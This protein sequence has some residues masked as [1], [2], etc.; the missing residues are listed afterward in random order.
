MS[1]HT[2]LR[3]PEIYTEPMKFIPERWMG[4]AEEVRALD[5]FFVP[6]AKG[7]SSCMGQRYVASSS[8]TSSRPVALIYNSMTYSWLYAVIG[9]VVRKFQL[10]LH[11]T[12]EK[13]VEISRDCFNGQTV[14]GLNLINVKVTKE[15]N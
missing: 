6:F 8:F 11:E 7:N 13:S 12:D 4:P 14:P 2:I 9:T 3:N 10:E 1:T 5:K 15:F